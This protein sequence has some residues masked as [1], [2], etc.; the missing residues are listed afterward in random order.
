MHRPGGDPGLRALALFF[1]ASCTDRPREADEALDLAVAAGVPARALHEAALQVM[2]YAGFP[3]AIDAL[4]RLAARRAGPDGP[5][6]PEPGPAA[7]R[8]VFGAVY[9]EGAPAVLASLEALAPG[10][11]NWVLS[12]A[13]ARVLA[14][15]GLSLR[16][17][18]LLAVAALALMGLSAPLAGH[19]RG[20]LRNGSSPAEARDILSTSRALASAASPDAVELIDRT[21]ARLSRHGKRP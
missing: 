17:R 18:E 15:P 20:A 1:A 9:G 16:E 2:P 4:G 19:L 10:F 8:A 13:Y 14:R 12:G 3:R 11:S 6:G 21:L 7:G 5:L